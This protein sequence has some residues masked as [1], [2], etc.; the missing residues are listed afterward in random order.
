MTEFKKNSKTPKLFTKCKRPMLKKEKII[1][2]PKILNIKINRLSYT[3]YGEQIKNDVPITYPL[4]LNIK[5]V[6]YNLKSLLTHVGG[7]NFG[8]YMCVNKT[9]YPTVDIDNLT[10]VSLAHKKIHSLNW[11]FTS[12]KGFFIRYLLFRSRR[13]L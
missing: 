7:A 3:V 2:Y 6:I 11:C 13:I 10:Y 8:H 5:G 1:K 4:K 12:D 9:W